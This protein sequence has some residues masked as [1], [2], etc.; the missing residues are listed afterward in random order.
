MVASEWPKAHKAASQTL[1]HISKIKDNDLNQSSESPLISNNSEDANQSNDLEIN[2][3][4]KTPDLIGVKMDEDHEQVY[5]YLGLNPSLMLDSEVSNKNTL[6]HIIRPGQDEKL[7]LEEVQKQYSANR[8]KRNKKNKAIQVKEVAE[9]N[10]ENADSFIGEED[11]EKTELSEL[12]QEESLTNS[13][14]KVEITTSD[15]NEVDL[16]AT[17]KELDQDIEDPRRRSRWSSASNEGI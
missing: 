9:N 3:S 4:Q 17:E 7:V 1:K 5:S 2:N 6:I 8:S 15:K 13:N 11:L 16:I 12:V 10:L 14:S